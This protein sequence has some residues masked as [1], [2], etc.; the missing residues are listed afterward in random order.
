MKRWPTL[1]PLFQFMHEILDGLHV[2][3]LL[4]A[5]KTIPIDNAIL[6]TCDMNKTG[7]KDNTIAKVGQGEDFE[8]LEI[9]RR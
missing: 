5:Q 3:I 9:N 8:R 7:V 4:K 6:K 1:D 2:S